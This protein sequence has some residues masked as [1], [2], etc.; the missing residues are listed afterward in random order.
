MNEQF[1][2]N[3]ETDIKQCFNDQYHIKCHQLLNILVLEEIPALI[4]F[5]RKVDKSVNLNIPEV[6]GDYQNGYKDAILQIKREIYG[7]K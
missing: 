2:N 6:S 1:L 4:E 7:N 3:I 5:V